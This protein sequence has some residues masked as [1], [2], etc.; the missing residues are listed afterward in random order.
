MPL[1]RAS[2]GAQRRLPVKVKRMRARWQFHCLPGRDDPRVAIEIKAKFESAGMKAARP[3]QFLIRREIMPLETEAEAT[4]AAEQRPPACADGVPRDRFAEC[5]HGGNNRSARR[6]RC[7]FASQ[8]GATRHEL[9]GQRLQGPFRTVRRVAP[10]AH[11]LQRGFVGGFDVPIGLRGYGALVP[12]RMHITKLFRRARD[13]KRRVP[14]PRAQI[15]RMRHVITRLKFSRLDGGARRDEREQFARA[16]DLHGLG[17]QPARAETGR[18]NIGI[19]LGFIAAQKHGIVAQARIQTRPIHERLV[20]HRFGLIEKLP[21]LIDVDRFEVVRQIR[22]DPPRITVADGAAQHVAAIVERFTLRGVTDQHA[23]VL[24]VRIEL[25][26]QHQL[27]RGIDFVDLIRA[28]FRLS[29]R[30]QKHS[31]QNGDDRDNHEQLDEG[32]RRRL[33]FRFE[34]H[35]ASVARAGG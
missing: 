31:R 5:G 22:R 30:R 20:R 3:I 34:S 4:K 32:K 26:R 8:L 19:K 28:L 15:R 25:P 21:R 7:G 24:V 9:V 23:V 18:G 29:Q 1:A 27:S 2:R 11:I 6:R 33:G 17:D 35:A 10:P 12:A 16:L 14:L 13:I